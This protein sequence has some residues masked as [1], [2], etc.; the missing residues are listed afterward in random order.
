MQIE[1]GWIQTRSGKKFY[2]LAPRPG[3]VDINDIAHAL[4]NLCRFTGHCD[5]YSVAQHSVHVAK[6]VSPPARLL[7]LL[8]DAAEAYMGDIARPWK[9]MLYVEDGVGQAIHESIKLREKRLL[10]VILSA[11]GV[12][13][14]AEWWDEIEQADMTMLVTEARDLMAPVHPD[15]YHTETNGFK[16]MLEKVEPMSPD[17]ARHVFLCEWKKLNQTRGQ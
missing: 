15:W 11:L 3:S 14:R 2:P 5:F 6:L 12:E 8:H 7:A 10:D 17:L 13:Q 1:T 9:R 4:A 16:A